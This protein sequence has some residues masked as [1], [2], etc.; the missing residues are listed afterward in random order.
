MTES[1]K[2]R[3]GKSAMI[4]YVSGIDQPIYYRIHQE[5]DTDGK[6]SGGLQ[7]HGRGTGIDTHEPKSKHIVLTGLRSQPSGGRSTR[8]QQTAGFH[9]FLLSVEN[10][11]YAENFL[12][13]RPKQYVG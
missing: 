7:L 12:K 3:F 10:V 1:E 4:R 6:E 9:Y 5:Q 8:T 2:E 11:H 13:M